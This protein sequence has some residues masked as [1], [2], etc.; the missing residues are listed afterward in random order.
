MCPLTAPCSVRMRALR[1]LCRYRAYRLWRKL[2]VDRLG[3]PLARNS[4]HQQR[5]R[6]DCRN[7]EAPLERG[8]RNQGCS[9]PPL[10]HVQSLGHPRTCRAAELCH[11]I[12]IVTG[13]SSFAPFCHSQ[14]DLS[15]GRTRPFSPE[16]YRVGLRLN[17]HS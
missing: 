12:V 11:S 7:L 2:W 3:A 9:D 1:E 10:A 4:N 17:D 16:R 15:R 6:H 5:Q 14:I 8:A 13:P